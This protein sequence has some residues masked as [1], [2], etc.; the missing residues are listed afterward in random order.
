MTG[1]SRAV[2]IEHMFDTREVNF[3]GRRELN[4]MTTQRS[5]N[6]V[7]IVGRQEVETEL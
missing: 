6:S 2:R 7:L 3:K 5:N 4:L 1:N